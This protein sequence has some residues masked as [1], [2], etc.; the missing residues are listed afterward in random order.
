M[1]SFFCPLDDRYAN[2]LTELGPVGES[3]FMKYRLEIEIKYFLEMV[4]IK[5]RPLA[6]EVITELNNLLTVDPTTYI[7]D[8]MIC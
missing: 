7:N 2:S 8:I 5:N 3:A 1:A 6:Q 4:K